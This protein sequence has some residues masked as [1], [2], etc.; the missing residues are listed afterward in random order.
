MKINNLLL[1]LFASSS[2]ISCVGSQ[3]N[4][5]PDSNATSHSNNLQIQG[6]PFSSFTLTPTS[7]AV[8]SGQPWGGISTSIGKATQNSTMMVMITVTAGRKDGIQGTQLLSNNNFSL[9][10][11][12]NGWTNFAFIANI[13]FTFTGGDSYT[14]NN[15]GVAQSGIGANNVWSIYGSNG[16]YVYGGQ[17]NNTSQATIACTNQNTGNN[18]NFYMLQQ[19]GEYAFWLSDHSIF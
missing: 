4:N 2:L 8:T 12:A 6:S 15:I 16:T 9:I 5:N 1:I 3:D 14:C 18:T 17:D 7:Y 19:Q 10:S 13:N 11:Q